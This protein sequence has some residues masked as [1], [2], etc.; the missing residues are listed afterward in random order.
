MA[1]EDLKMG[2]LGGSPPLILGKRDKKEKVCKNIMLKANTP[3]RH[4]IIV[5]GNLWHIYWY[6]W[7]NN[8]KLDSSSQT[9]LFYLHASL[10]LQ[11]QGTSQTTLKNPGSVPAWVKRGT[12]RK[13]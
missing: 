4:L 5:S 6:F 11:P 9:E 3:G 13:N 7:C 2:G 12:V 1:R 10:T 8:I